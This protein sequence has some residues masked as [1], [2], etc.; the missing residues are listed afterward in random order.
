MTENADDLD[1][2]LAE[3]LEVGRPKDPED[4]P[5]SEKLSAYHASE[6]S[7]EEEDAIQEHLVR[8]TFCTERLLNLQRFLEPMEEERPEVADFGAEAGWRKMREKIGWKGRERSSGAPWLRQA[9]S[10]QPAYARAAA[11][12]VILGLAAY[13][14]LQ[15][16]L[17]KQPQLNLPFQDL[18]TTNTYRS[19]SEAPEVRLSDDV[20]HFILSLETLADL[21]DSD[22][23]VEIRNRAQNLV[24]S[25]D[26]L[27]KSTPYRF[28]LFLPQGL[29][30]AGDY[31]IS[32]LGKKGSSVPIE[33]YLFKILR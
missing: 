26:G 31:E 27:R 5:I 20:N 2:S 28:V 17:L 14:G 10:L 23:R 24:L 29:F 32:V 4:H 30:P 18:Q 21:P 9:L 25:Q 3:F 1:G 19:S 22:Y 15:H 11:W 7:S 33:K 13:A 12:L 16:R 6:L 8:C